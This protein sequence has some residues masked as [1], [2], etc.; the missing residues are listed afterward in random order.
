MHA[1]YT[2]HPPANTS[3]NTWVYRRRFE[4]FDLEWVRFF[5]GDLAA[6]FFPFGGS[7]A[8]ASVF[9]RFGLPCS[10]GIIRLPSTGPP[11]ARSSVFALRAAAF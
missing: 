5:L 3:N 9:C 8:G 1:T 7:A 6:D 4:N 10:P 11:R 2:H